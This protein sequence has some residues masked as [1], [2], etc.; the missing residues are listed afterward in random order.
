M[1]DKFSIKSY[2]DKNG[3]WVSTDGL[4][5]NTPKSGSA[6]FEQSTGKGIGKS[7]YAT[8]LKNSP[9]ATILK[10]ITEGVKNKSPMTTFNAFSQAGIQLKS[11]AKKSAEGLVGTLEE[12]KRYSELFS[13]VK[14]KQASPEESAEFKQLQSRNRDT[15]FKL[16]SA[17]GPAPVASLK[18]VGTKAV[19]ETAEEVAGKVAK[20]ASGKGTPTGAPPSVLPGG[21]GTRER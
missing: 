21:G 17:F 5:Y 16:V 9:A 20:K 18:S 7:S 19:K 6:G 8:N 1:A 12:R 2:I 3:H 14:N 4:L 13:K 10:G 11:D 15:A